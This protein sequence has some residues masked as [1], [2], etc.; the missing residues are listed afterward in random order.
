MQWPLPIKHFLP[1][2]QDV[3]FLPLFL[4][5]LLFSKND[6]LQMISYAPLTIGEYGRAQIDSFIRFNLVELSSERLT[7]T[8]TTCPAVQLSVE[9]KTTTIKKDRVAGLAMR[10]TT[11]SNNIFEKFCQLTRSW[12]G[13]LG[14]K[15]LVE[16][17]SKIIVIT[18]GEK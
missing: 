9:H 18:V 10:I 8:L 12:W 4:F 13:S 5:V 3:N 7:E 1:Q 15:D 6:K 11:R 17:K 14:W 16:F 2:L